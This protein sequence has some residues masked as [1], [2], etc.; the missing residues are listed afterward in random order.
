MDGNF[1]LFGMPVPDGFGKRGR[2][3]HMVTL[4]STNKVKL[5][6]ALGWSNERIAH[7]LGLSLPTLRKHYFQVL[8]VRDFQR[9]M[10]D[11]ARLSKLWELGMAGNVAAMREFDRML[12]R[13]D[14]MMADAKWR[15]G[16]DETPAQK[17]KLGKKEQA[18]IAAA[19][20]EESDAWGS[21]LAFRGKVN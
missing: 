5:L 16:D 8:K 13:N 11:A 15:G 7:A 4:E 1:D 21:D 17:E 12:E 14:A 19:A 2:P 9:D 6:L 20:V 3:E 18:Q 10:L